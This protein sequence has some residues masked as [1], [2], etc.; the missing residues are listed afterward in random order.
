MVLNVSYASLK[1][2]AKKEKNVNPSYENVIILPAP[3]GV[4]LHLGPS[5]GAP[6]DRC[7]QIRHRQNRMQ[8]TWHSRKQGLPCWR[9]LLFSWQIPHTTAYAWLKWICASMHQF[10][11]TFLTWASH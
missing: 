6:R 3:T 7:N 1:G 5:T 11:T 8:T 4:Q 2:C 9:S 10:C